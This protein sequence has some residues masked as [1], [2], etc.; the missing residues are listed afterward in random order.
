MLF[1]IKPILLKFLTVRL[2]ACIWVGMNDLVISIQCFLSF[3]VV[4]N[5]DPSWAGSSSL[6]ISTCSA[7]SLAR[8]MLKINFQSASRRKFYSFSAFLSLLLVFAWIS[9]DIRPWTSDLDKLAGWPVRSL[10][11]TLCPPYTRPCCQP[12]TISGDLSHVNRFPAFCRYFYH[13]KAYFEKHQL[14]KW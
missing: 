6:E 11:G 5:G 4:S 7:Y 9:A 10:F 1:L 12:S 2:N 14:I 8:F 3:G 13:V